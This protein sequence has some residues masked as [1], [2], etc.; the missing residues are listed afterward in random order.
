MP[1]IVLIDADDLGRGMLSCY[2]QKWFATPNI[3]RLSEE[4][5]RFTRAY[6]CAFCGPA[7]S[8]SSDFSSASSGLALGW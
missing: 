6:G 7:D 4:G 3:D 8:S 1:N 2:G 5:M